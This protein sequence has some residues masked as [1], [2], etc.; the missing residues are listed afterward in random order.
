MNRYDTERAIQRANLPAASVSILMMLLTRIDSHTGEMPYPPSLSAL[1]RM[2]G[3][4]ETTVCRHLRALD[5]AGWVTRERPPDDLARRLHVHTSY[6]VHVPGSTVQPARQHGAAS[7]GSTVQPA[8]G[9]RCSQAGRTVQG[10]SERGQR[11]DQIVTSGPDELREIARAEIAQAT[12]RPATDRL[13]RA[14]VRL[15][16]DGRNVRDPAQYL[17]EAIRREPGRF[18][19]VSVPPAF[20]DL[21]R[22]Q[23]EAIARSEG[24]T[25]E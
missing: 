8:Q 19:P 5:A 7:A 15:V 23:A 18:A 13:A 1:S 2:T 12:G 14:A 22:L 21:A 11:A 6:E 24:D 16:L 25:H 4:H 10:K 9:A 17:R 20:A 3:L